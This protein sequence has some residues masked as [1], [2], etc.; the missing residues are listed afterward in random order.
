MGKGLMTFS[1]MILKR[2]WCLKLE[3]VVGTG[4]TPVIQTRGGSIAAVLAAMDIMDLRIRTGWCQQ[5][6]VK[7]HWRGPT[8][9]HTA[10]LTSSDPDCL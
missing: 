1:L 10:C 5:L 8:D 4:D 3:D 9:Q 2:R 6:W 7:Q